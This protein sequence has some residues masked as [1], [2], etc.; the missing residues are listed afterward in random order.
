MHSPVIGS[1]A[2]ARAAALGV[3]IGGD[4]DAARDARTVV[5]LWADPNKIRLL[6]TAAKA[7]TAKLIANLALAVS[8]EALVE[9]VRL[10]DAG[11]LTPEE[12]VSILGITTIAPIA[13]LK[14]GTVI[15]R[16]FTDTQFSAAL[17]AK[18]ARLMLATSQK[19]LPAVALVADALDRAT[20]A[21][22]G[23]QDFSV[24]ARE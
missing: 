20:A 10:G 6:D 16:T 13:A 7:A 15:D 5:A 22:D 23:E 21:G 18:D 2:P 3:L 17:L 1:L 19:P 24:I 8:M 14:G 11:R 4:H 12:V 9:S